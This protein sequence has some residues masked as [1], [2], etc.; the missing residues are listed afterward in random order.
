MRVNRS[1]DHLI[2]KFESLEEK[3]AWFGAMN[4]MEIHN[5]VYRAF[6][7]FRYLP[8]T[9]EIF[10]KIREMSPEIPDYYTLP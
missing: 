8:G 6:P 4:M 9:H 7:Q 3:Y 10:T 5:R 2:L 1:G